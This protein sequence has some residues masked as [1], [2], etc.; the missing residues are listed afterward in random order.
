MT[1]IQNARLLPALTEGYEGTLADIHIVGN[2]IDKILP[3]GTG[4]LPEDATVIDAGK[5][6]VIPGLWDLHAHLYLQSQTC[7][8]DILMKNAGQELF[9]CYHYALEYLKQGYTTLRDVGTAMDAALF[10]RDAINRGDLDGPRV[11]AS[12]IILTPTEMGNST[13]P[14]LYAMADSPDELRKIARIELEKGADFLKYMG[15]GATTNKNGQPGRR[16]ATDSELRAIQEVAE[17]KGT[18]VAVHCHSAEGIEACIETGI[19]T[20][21]HG[22]FVTDRAIEMLLRSGN[23]SFIVPTASIMDVILTEEVEGLMVNADS[24]KDLLRFTF[25]RWVAAYKAGVKLGWGTDVVQTDFIAHPGLEFTA[26]KKYCDF[27]NID[28]LL[29]AT[30]YSAEIAGYGDTLGTVKEGKLADL[31]VVDGN[32]DED[33]AAMTRPMLHVIRDGKKLV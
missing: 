23:N 29:Q 18:Y 24:K 22:S 11:I 17:L 16:I 20:I 31:I 4:N 26:R 2:K 5:K 25:T 15:S 33:I 12:G 30:K 1:I 8:T 10:V 14:L 27:S 32:P 21:E 3:C 28:M 7:N 6:S 19:H 13:F 9:D